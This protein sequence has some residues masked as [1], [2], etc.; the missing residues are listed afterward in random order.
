[1]DKIL[2]RPSAWPPCGWETRPEP[3]SEDPNRQPSEYVNH[4]PPEIARLYYE[5]PAK[6]SGFRK[7]LKKRGAF[8]ISV[9]GNGHMMRGDECCQRCP[10]CGEPPLDACRWCGISILTTHET[11]D[12]VPLRCRKCGLPHEWFDDN[13]E[14]VMLEKRRAAL[15]RPRAPCSPPAA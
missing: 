9:C 15:V 4:L 13:N 3:Y 2:P 7:F 6:N 5:W 11:P 14:A 10:D 1:M 12:G 8:E